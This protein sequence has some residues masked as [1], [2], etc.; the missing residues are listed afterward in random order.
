MLMLA[1]ALTLL[2]VDT[3][4]SSKLQPDGEAGGDG[5]PS[6]APSDKAPPPTRALS[7]G[8]EL[9]RGTEVV[10]QP[11]FPSEEELLFAGGEH[12]GVQRFGERERTSW[13]QNKE[14]QDSM[15]EVQAHGEIVEVGASNVG[16]QGTLR[17]Q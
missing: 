16:R 9:G 1:I 5:I 8:A 13:E 12:G 17:L 11:L 14:E 3:S 6:P 15:V 4:S 2:L 7:D 10:S